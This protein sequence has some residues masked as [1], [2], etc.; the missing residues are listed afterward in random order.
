MKQVL[1]AT[2]GV[3]GGGVEGGHM[4]GVSEAISVTCVLA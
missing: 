4:Y 1:Y 3:G 2:L